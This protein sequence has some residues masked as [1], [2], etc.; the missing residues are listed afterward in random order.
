[1]WAVLINKMT[2]FIHRL[3]RFGRRPAATQAHPLSGL[4]DRGV[5]HVAGSA[6]P[7]SAAAR[8]LLHSRSERRGTSPS[9][10]GK[11]ISRSKSIR[12]YDSGVRF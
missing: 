12:L 9:S 8:L 11:R 3:E 6:G 10:E 1:M 4:R 5:E 7:P 2:F